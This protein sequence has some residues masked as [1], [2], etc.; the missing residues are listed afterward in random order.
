MSSISSAHLNL[1]RDGLITIFTKL[2]IVFYHTWK[3]F[4]PE[5]TFLRLFFKALFYIF[6][7]L[8]FLVFM[9]IT[10][11]II[12]ITHAQTIVN[13]PVSLTKNFLSSPIVIKSNT[14]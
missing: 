6:Y 10:S 12:A 1:A 13:T 7:E 14:V 5:K 3:N 2:P 9:Y 8:F 11:I 4:K